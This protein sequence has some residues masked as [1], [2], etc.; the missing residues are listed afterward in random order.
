MFD[1]TEKFYM[2]ATDG[3]YKV[4]ATFCLAEGDSESATFNPDEV[5]KKAVLSSAKYVLFSHNHLSNGVKPSVNDIITTKSLVKKLASG[6]VMV[7]DHII[8]NNQEYL[9]FNENGLMS[10]MYSTVD[11]N[12][13]GNLLNKINLPISQGGTKL[14]DDLALFLFQTANS[15]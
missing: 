15:L 13:I 2:I 5:L 4:L 12:D 11:D 10:L 7:L 1:N 9:S 8:I 6:G 3:K 14:D